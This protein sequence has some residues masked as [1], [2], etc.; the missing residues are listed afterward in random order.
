[1][2]IKYRVINFT[3]NRL[4]L[5]Q[6]IVYAIKFRGLTQEE[7]AEAAGISPT[8]VMELREGTNLN[9]ELRSLLGVI[10]ALDLDPRDYF[11]LED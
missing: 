9:P 6:E 11:H 5:A 1:M 2:T 4:K 7:I 8:T 10:N 3:L